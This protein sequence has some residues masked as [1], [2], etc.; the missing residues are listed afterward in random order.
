[1]KIISSSTIETVCYKLLSRAAIELPP[2]VESAIRQAFEDETHDSGVRRRDLCNSL[3]KRT[4][5]GNLAVAGEAAELA[6]EVGRVS[7][8]ES[9][10]CEWTQ[11]PRKG[12][13]SEQGLLIWAQGEQTAL[14]NGD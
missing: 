12:L 1:M 5:E 13:V 11:Q 9:F 10:L 7:R 14:R 8:R 4:T 6:G 3:Q 2:E